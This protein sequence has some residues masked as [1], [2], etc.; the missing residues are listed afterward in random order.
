[1]CTHRAPGNPRDLTAQCFRLTARGRTCVELVKAEA[2]VV[3]SLSRYLHDVLLMCGTG[4]WFH[5]LHQFMPA[6]ALDD[7]IGTLV[8]LGLIESVERELPLN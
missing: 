3:G 6:R 5:Q 1:M 7:S 4:T 2:E 8:D